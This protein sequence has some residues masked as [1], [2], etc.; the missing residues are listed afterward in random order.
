MITEEDRQDFGLIC[1]HCGKKK[2]YDEHP[3]KYA[4]NSKEEFNQILES[5]KNAISQE[6]AG[7]YQ[8]NKVFHCQNSRW[9]CPQSSEAIICKSKADT[10]EFLKE[11][12]DWCWLIPRA[13]RLYKGDFK[14]HWENYFGIVFKF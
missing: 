4:I 2:S 10:I 7:N 8:H 14:A 1:P 3:D 9:I 5:L 12:S 11:L 6:K 13:F